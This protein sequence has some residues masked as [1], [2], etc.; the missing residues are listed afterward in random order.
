MYKITFHC[1]DGHSYRINIDTV[2]ELK[3]CLINNEWLQLND[4]LVI[5]TNHIVYLEIDEM[6]RE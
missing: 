1:D 6:V 2:E 3:E 5:N 4:N